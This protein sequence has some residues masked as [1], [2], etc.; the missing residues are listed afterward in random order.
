MHPI[1]LPNPKTWVK[2]GES[3]LGRAPAPPVSYLLAFT[4]GRPLCSKQ[5]WILPVPAAF[6]VSWSHLSLAVM[7]HLVHEA[8]NK[9]ALGRMENA[10]P[11]SCIRLEAVLDMVEDGQGSAF[12]GA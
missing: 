11:R 6:N 1:S 2:S 8:A 3:P 7:H 5:T 12:Q 9:D 10:Q 4:Q